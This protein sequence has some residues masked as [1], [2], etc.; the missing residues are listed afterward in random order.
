MLLE[1]LRAGGYKPLCLTY[2]TL[3]YLL[4]LLYLLTYILI[5]DLHPVPLPIKHFYALKGTRFT[6]YR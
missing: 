2:Y 6:V 1:G 3:L 5:T 4:Y